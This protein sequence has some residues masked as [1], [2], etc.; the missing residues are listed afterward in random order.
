MGW[1]DLLGDIARYGVP[2]ATTALLELLRD[3]DPDIRY[4]AAV[5]CRGPLGRE[6]VPA[7]CAAMQGPDDQ[8]RE[9]AVTAV[10]DGGPEWAGAVVPALV[11]AFA[12]AQVLPEKRT[13]LLFALPADR[14]SGPPESI[15][16]TAQICDCNA[17]SKA[18]IIQ[19]V[20]E[21]A[22]SVQAVSG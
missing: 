14:R 20:L 3:G 9:E 8:V 10:Q 15:P 2:Q 16:D 18:R 21:G 17:V 6:F 19:A 5:Q 13:E 12:E 4:R 22:R 11:R 7:L 1:F